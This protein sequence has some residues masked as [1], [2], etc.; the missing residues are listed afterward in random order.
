MTLPGMTPKPSTPPFSSLPSNS[1]CM[2]RQIPRNGFPACKRHHLSSAHH[3]EVLQMQHNGLAYT[4]AT[5]S[6]RDMW[7]DT[8]FDVHY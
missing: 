5:A 4:Q 7:S 1:S 3:V 8:L 6:L 2:P